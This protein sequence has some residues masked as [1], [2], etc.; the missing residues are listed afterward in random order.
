MCNENNS[1]QSIKLTQ[2]NEN[3]DFEREI[4]KNAYY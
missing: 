4:K 1:D 3:T 2:N